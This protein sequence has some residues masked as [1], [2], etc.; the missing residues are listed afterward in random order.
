MGNG[1]MIIGM[2][3]MQSNQPPALEEKWFEI[4][5]HLLGGECIKV[6]APGDMLL[7][8]FLRELVEC[9]GLPAQD[10]EAHPCHWN[11]DSATYKRT[12]DLTKTVEQEV[13]QTTGA[14]LYLRR[15]VVAG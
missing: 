4:S 6:S 11:L 3:G 7:S 9:V 2:N 8:D 13:L 14:V 15:S 5:I 12:C 1:S 10:A